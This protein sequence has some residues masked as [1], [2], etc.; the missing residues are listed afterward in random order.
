MILNLTQHPASVDQIEADVVNL[1]AKS[2]DELKEALTFKG[3]PT[4]QEIEHRV[5]WIYQIATNA[6]VDMSECYELIEEELDSV[7]SEIMFDEKRFKAMN[8]SFMI[9][10]APYLMGPLQLE[11][12]NI[13]TVL[14]AYSD[15]VSAEETQADGSVRKVNVFKHIG[16]VEALIDS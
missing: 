1:P 9:G 16:F 4:V 15:R 11:L 12:S 3:L 2:L 8:I 5:N 14:Y 13:G 7:T 10:G 6:I